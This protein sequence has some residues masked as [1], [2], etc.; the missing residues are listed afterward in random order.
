M[1]KTLLSFLTGTVLLIATAVSAQNVAINA[2]GATADPSAMLDVNATNAGLLA[3]RVTL[4]SLTDATT[5]VNPA[6]SLLVYN[7]GGAVPA[8]FYYNSGTPG[9]AFV[10]YIFYRSQL[11]GFT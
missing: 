11:L 10:E 4:A 7:T 5:I 9:V 8:G 2:T 6:T 3:P 1:K